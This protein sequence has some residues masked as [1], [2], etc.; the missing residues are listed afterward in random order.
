MVTWVLYL[1]VGLVIGGMAGFYFAKMDDLPRKQKKA[2]EDKLQ[3]TEQE[4]IDYKDQVTGHF[5]ETAA[6]INNMTESYQK[7]HKHLAQGVV[8]LCSN[9]IEVDKLQV[10]P[11]QLLTESKNSSV[12]GLAESEAPK[13]NS[14]GNVNKNREEKA[15]VVK[16]SAAGTAVADM[17]VDE[18]DQESPSATVVAPPDLTTIRSESDFQQHPPE[19]MAVAEESEDTS[20]DKANKGKT[21]S[22]SRTVH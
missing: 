12:T 9:A 22:G 13:T 4:L 17:A 7:V 10:S 18:T 8:Q 5:K 11:N 6:L 20:T 2:L 3:L 16:V 21:R 14:K 15:V 19:T 1:C